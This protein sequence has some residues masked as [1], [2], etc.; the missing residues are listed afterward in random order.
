MQIAEQ[1]FE[2][3]IPNWNG[4]KMLADCL[5]SL[6]KQSCQ[7]FVVTVVDNGSTDGSLLLLEKD[8]PEVKVVRF[9]HNTGFCVAINSGIKQSQSP[10]V[11][12]LNNDMEVAP[13]CLEKLASALEKY[14]DYDFFSLKMMSFHQR[15]YIDGAGD[16]VLRGGVGYRLGTMEENSPQYQHDRDCFGACAGA[17]LYSR[18]FFKKVGLFDEEFFA[19]LEDVDLNFRANRLGLRCRFVASAVVYHIGSATSGSKINDFTV[20]L[21]TRNNVYVLAKNY[22]LGLCLRFFPS[23][24]V[25][26]LMWLAFCC[27]HKMLGPYFK[28]VWQGLRAFPDFFAKGRDY[29]T[30]EKILPVNEFAERIRSSEKKAVQSL[31]ARRE[32]GSKNNFLLHFYVR[33]F[34]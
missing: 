4:E 3:I 31:I 22:S 14:P 5:S 13:D 11:L 2:I 30:T 33:L 1:R 16:E 25:Y 6:E 26:Q 10:W 34:L 9:D 15:N 27:K 32:A 7:D 19:Y 12:L 24:F 18:D 29:K 23:I 21:S 20:R 28:G 8:F 17:A